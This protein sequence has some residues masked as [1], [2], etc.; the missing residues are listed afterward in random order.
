MIMTMTM[1]MIMI[2]L[3]T[4]SRGGCGHHSMTLIQKFLPSVMMII[5]SMK[6]SESESESESVSVRELELESM[7]IPRIVMMHS[8]DH[9][10]MRQL[11][12]CWLERLRI[13]HMEA[14][15]EF[16][17]AKMLSTNPQVGLEPSRSIRTH[18]QEV[19]AA[20]SITVQYSLVV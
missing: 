9:W 2:M 19:L 17:P 11:H 8:V 14:Q 4:P 5:P 3:R 7:R 10:R 12:P 15:N 18:N 13:V 6:G 16:T 1:I 20:A